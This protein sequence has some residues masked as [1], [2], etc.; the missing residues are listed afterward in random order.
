MAKSISPNLPR[1]RSRPRGQIPAADGEHGAA[2]RAQQHFSADGQDIAR[3]A[4]GRFDELGELGHIVRQP[5]VK[6]D[7]PD[8][9]DR[10]EQRHQRFASAHTFE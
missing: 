4:A 3:V 1:R 7:L 8:D 6:I 10:A 9:Q 2:Q 5:Q